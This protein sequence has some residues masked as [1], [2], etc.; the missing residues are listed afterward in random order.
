MGVPEP[1]VD[2]SA[3]KEPDTQAKEA[4]PIVQQADK[5]VGRAGQGARSQAGSQPFPVPQK[6]SHLFSDSGILISSIV[7]PLVVVLV[8]VVQWLPVTALLLGSGVH[9]YICIHP[10]PLALDVHSYRYAFPRPMPP[11]TSVL[12]GSRP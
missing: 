6:S 9:T 11:S 7:L 8:V 5:A 1:L 4:G 2:F 10:Y 12:K 3:L